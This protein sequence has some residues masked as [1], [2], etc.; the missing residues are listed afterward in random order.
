MKLDIF[1]WRLLLRYSWWQLWFW[2]LLDWHLH[3]KS[4]RKCE[5]QISGFGRSKVKISLESGKPPKFKELFFGPL[6]AFTENCINICSYLQAI[7]LTE[8]ER[9][10]RCLSHCLLGGSKNTVWTTVW[11]YLVISVIRCI[12]AL[13]KQTGSMHSFNLAIFLSVYVHRTH[14]IKYLPA[15]F[16]HDFS[17]WKTKLASS[18]WLGY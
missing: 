1:F 10:K 16:V 13:W 5:L 18:S 17:S 11:H 3:L 7:L 15:V 6:L 8:R 2:W 4:L 14:S 12:L 9:D